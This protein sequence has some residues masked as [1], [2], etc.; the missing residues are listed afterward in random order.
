MKLRTFLLIACAAAVV[1]APAQK[2]KKKAKQPAPVEN[3]IPAPVDARLYSY[4]MG[5][6]QG[7]SLRNYLIQRMGVDSAY[8]NYAIQAIREAE[9]LSLD[10]RMRRTAYAAGL[11]IARMNQTQVIPSLNKQAVGRT[12]STYAVLSEFT[13]GLV[14]VM[15]KRAS[16]S[17]DSAMHVA[18]RQMMHR[19]AMAKIEADKYR[20]EN[21]DWLAANAKKKDVKMLPSGLQYRVIRQGNGPVATDSTEVEAHYEG[22]LINGSVFDSSYKRGKPLAVKPNSVIKGWREALTMMPEGSVYE[23]FIP[24]GLGYGEQGA[25]EGIPPYST[26]VFKVEVVKVK[27]EAKP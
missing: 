13:R 21:V 2:R 11:E 14:E 18:E 3:K 6:A 16:I 5:V 19:E 7:E 9:H 4:A 25:G 10:D 20:Q 1:A 24:Y 26:L 8:V 27:T 17:V 23:L 22:K 15:E 12:D